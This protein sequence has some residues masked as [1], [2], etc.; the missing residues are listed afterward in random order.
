[1]GI[2]IE[3][4]LKDREACPVCD[5]HGDTAERCV[6]ALLSREDTCLFYNSIRYNKDLHDNAD[7]L[8]LQNLRSSISERKVLEYYYRSDPIVKH[9]KILA[10]HDQNK[11][12]QYYYQKYVY[13]IVQLLKAGDPSTAGDKI[14]KMLDELEAEHGSVLQQ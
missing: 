7:I 14:F 3:Q 10:G 11:F 5:T 2:T 9:I 6:T 8:L 1:M 13:E 4:Y 12:W